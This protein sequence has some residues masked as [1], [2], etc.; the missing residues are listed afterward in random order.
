MNP[1]HSSDLSI[2]VMTQ[3]QI[4]EILNSEIEALLETLNEKKDNL[5]DDETEGKPFN[6]RITFWMMLSF[7]LTLV[8]IYILNC[9]VNPN[10]NKFECK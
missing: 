10:T 1:D 5:E 4:I 9:P 6:V 2:V 3:N 7:L 8:I